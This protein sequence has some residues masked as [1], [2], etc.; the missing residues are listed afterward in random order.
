[1]TRKVL[2]TFAFCALYLV[3]C[4]DETTVF[5]TETNAISVEDNKAN[6]DASVVYDNSGVI[7]IVPDGSITGKSRRAAEDRASDYPLT[8]IAQITP[9]SYNGGEN[10]A[11]SH[12]DI[13]GNFAYVSYNTAGIDYA[14]GIDVINISDP[15]NPIVAYRIY[16]PVDLNSITYDDGFIYAVGS[17]TEN[18]I[19][20]E[21][22]S[23]AIYK[24]PVSSEGRIDLSS[25]E[26]VYKVGFAA[27]DVAVSGDNLF[28]TSGKDGLVTRYNK[29]TMEAMEELPYADLRS[30]AVHDNKVAVLDASFGVRIIDE[31]FTETNQIAI[32]GDFREADKRT[33][34]F[35]SNSIFVPEGAEGAGIYDATTGVL[36]ERI[37]I[38]INPD[39]V[40]EE[41]IVTNGVAIN[42]DV[43][44]MANGGAGLCIS[45]ENNGVDLVGIVD[46]EGSINY[47]RSEGEYIFAASGRKGLQIIRMDKPQDDET[48]AERCD[49]VDSYRGRNNVTVAQGETE[50]YRVYN[51]FRSI[52]VEGSLL[53]CGLAAVRNN[54]TIEA[55]GLFEM[56]GTLVVGR[57]GRGNEIRIGE[58]SNLKIEGNYLTIYGDLVLEDNATLE[59]LGDNTTVNV[60]G[61]VIV[62]DNATV[63]G[64]FTDT[65]NKF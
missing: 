47:I 26:T 64:N 65:Q 27:N 57:S 35:N 62:G 50:E 56:Y 17:T 8:M 12:V 6:L 9:F 37:P 38:P 42:E 41:N 45:E 21:G 28:V 30:L 54:V 16:G 32:N 5:E 23:A 52:T 3:S 58:G 46:L 10:L 34:A 4:S 13:E 36:Q 14:G 19:L 39:N 55:G 7:G 29:N 63:T 15:Y 25:Y 53:F 48:L 51:Y 18:E 2:L 20:T 44:L 33:L 49:T 61:N 11:A 31:T 60:Y 22:L 24:F 40:A 1:M 59:F 43:F